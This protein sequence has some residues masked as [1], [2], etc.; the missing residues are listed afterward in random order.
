L[1]LATDPDSGNHGAS[2]AVLREVGTTNRTRIVDYENAINENTKLL[3]RV[4]PSNFTI[5]VLRKNHP[6]RP[7]AVGQRVIYR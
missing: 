1:K 4:H 5:T 2:G 6:C 7:G 3:L